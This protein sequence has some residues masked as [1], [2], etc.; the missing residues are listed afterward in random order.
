MW[1]TISSKEVFKHPRLSL[2][3]DEIIL[4][5]GTKSTY[6]KF[7]NDGRC[8]VTIIAKRDDG[9]LFLQKEYSYPPNKK[10]FQFPGGL[11][12]AEE[13]PE[14]GA[15]R[16][17]MEEA[18]YKADEL[19][20]LGSYLRDNRRSSSIM[21]VYLAS[22]LKEEFLAADQEESFEDFWLSEEEIDKLIKNG[23]IINCHML[24][25]WCLYKNKKN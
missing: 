10:I 20:L 22:G 15:N 24:A 1:K 7:K 2:M 17:L 8:A 16:E 18:K 3:E 11:V 25:A 9:K 19:I 12:P 6:L 5:D 4:P 23:E 13:R 21:Y 14:I